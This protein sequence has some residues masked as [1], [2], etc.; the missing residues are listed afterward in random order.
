M[1]KNFLEVNNSPEAIF[2]RSLFKSVFERNI[3]VRKKTVSKN[4]LIK[5]S[6]SLTYAAHLFLVSF[7]PNRLLKWLNQ[8]KNTMANCAKH[9]N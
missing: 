9:K 2:L 6:S 5:M 8:P 4:R 7:A 1:A 3:K